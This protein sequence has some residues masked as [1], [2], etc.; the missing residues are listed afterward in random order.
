MIK[1]DNEKAKNNNLQIR[2]TPNIFVPKEWF[3][4]IKNKDVLCLASGGGQ[5]GPML[6]ASSANI[7]VFDN[8]PSQLQKEKS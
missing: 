3:G 8:S 7:T 5:Q 6:A 1:H 4:E 2:L